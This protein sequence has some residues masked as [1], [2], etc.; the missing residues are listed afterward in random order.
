MSSL[1]LT[2]GV[3]AQE[4]TL[5]VNSVA[6]DGDANIGDKVCATS[7]GECTLRAALDEVNDEII[8]ERWVIDF[9]QIPTT[10]EN[11]RQVARIVATGELDLNGSRVEIRGDT[12]PGWQA[13]DPP[14]VYIDGTNLSSS[15]V[16][17]LEVRS[18]ADTSSIVGLGIVG[19]PDDGINLISSTNDA[20]LYMSIQYCWIGIDPDGSANGNGT[21]AALFSEQRAGID[22]NRPSRVVIGAVGSNPPNGFDDFLLRFTEGGEN[23]IGAN[24]DYGIYLEHSES[25]SSS[26]QRTG[27]AM[28]NNYIGLLPDG[29]TPRGNG[30]YG[31]KIDYAREN[32]I[33]RVTSGGDTY[34]NYFAGNGS[35]AIFLNTN[36]TEVAANY[37]GITADASSTSS[38][39]APGQEA[40]LL[41]RPSR[42]QNNTI[43][44]NS[45]EDR[46]SGKGNVFGG[47]DYGI[48]AGMD[49]TSDQR[50]DSEDIRGN[51]FGV[52]PGGNSVP[53]GSAGVYTM[54]ADSLTIAA[55][56]FGNIGGGGPEDAAISIPQEKIGR[57]TI[58]NNLIGVLDDGSAHPIDGNGIYYNEP[59]FSATF[60]EDNVIGN[61][62]QN[63]ILISNGTEVLDGPI[64]Q[65]NSIG[66]TPPGADI[67]NGD[68]G[69]RF[70]D[71]VSGYVA[72]RFSSD[73]P[74]DG[75]LIGFNGGP[76][77]AVTGDDSRIQIRF[78][79]FRS[80]GGPM[81][82]L[83]DDGNTA[84]DGAD[85]D[86][87]TG[88]N[89]LLNTPE[90]VSFDCQPGLTADNLTLTYRV[91]TT[92]GNA[93]FD[94]TDGI[95]VD[96]Y[97]GSA[98]GIVEE[99]LTTDNYLNGFTNQT[100]T[101]SAANL[102]DQYLFLTTTDFSAS[103]P[104]REDPST[105]EFLSP[106]QELP[107]ELA[108]FDVIPTGD[109]GA[110]LT[111]QTVS[112]ENNDRFEIEHRAPDATA[113]AAAGTVQG[114]G[115]TTEPQRY[116]LS[117]TDLA[118]GTHTFRLRQIDVD[119]TD[120]VLDERT[121][122]VRLGTAFDLTIGPNP[123]R[124][125]ARGTLVLQEAQTV[126]AVVYDV[127]G[128]AVQTVHDGPMTAGKNDLTLDASTLGSGRYFLRIEGDA[129]STTES[130]TVVR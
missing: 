128:R 17:G 101:A 34:R 27:V 22:M 114:A 42:L 107:V 97:A 109:R 39:L 24:A 71:A 110:Q 65:R 19:F 30:L 8:Q 59:S 90:I 16:D 117:L 120:T 49:D 94:D 100:V 75:N 81:I 84:N 111:W 33:G 63:G 56:V 116:E 66:A 102:C 50:A 89:K 118:V 99:Y 78:N 127:L 14:V 28:G 113:F 21:I 72:P 98:P 52:T 103:S 18:D 129:F 130:I 104:D 55:N 73:P 29:T 85:G 58:S 105:S 122:Q 125:S 31:V 48:R 119:G 1:Y 62:T 35:G 80:N 106:A 112:E 6:D 25:A 76:G 44:F 37:F 93:N 60:I 36:G 32:Y 13:G 12:A 79:Q 4:Y 121:L 46:S 2:P 108:S 91:R 53:L 61:A 57:Q 74:S 5:N 77:V 3:H 38:T 70:T 96:L 115:T 83:G 92:S 9:S 124:T 88:P 87:D 54:F 7:S 64:I 45:G 67:G 11:G 26:Q 43:G 20:V 82:D 123:V 51:F 41:T 95:L 126:Q 69:I 47:Y 86:A 68:A 23:V 10:T 15:A 40:I